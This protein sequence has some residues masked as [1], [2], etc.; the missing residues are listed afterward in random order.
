V[1]LLFI[2]LA[3]NLQYKEIADIVDM[4][5][6]SEKSAFVCI[7]E[8]DSYLTLLKE[9]LISITGYANTLARE[10]STIVVS[11]QFQ[12]I[13]RQ[14]LEHVISPV[15]KLHS[16]LA[17]VQNKF[18]DVVADNTY[19]TQNELRDWLSQFYTMEDEKEVLEGVLG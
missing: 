5:T 15:E 13:T 4:S 6:S 8:I 7:N 1:F 3:R 11:I 14:R 17:A 19:T 9:K 10:I 2:Y 18:N 12:D 16:E